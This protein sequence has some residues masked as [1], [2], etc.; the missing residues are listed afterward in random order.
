MWVLVAYWYSLWP[1]IRTVEVIKFKMTTRGVIVKLMPSWQV[2]APTLFCS[3]DSDKGRHYTESNKTVG[4]GG[5]DDVIMD[6]GA[7]TIEVVFGKAHW[8]DMSSDEFKK[9]IEE[10]EYIYCKLCQSNFSSIES[11]EFLIKLK[12]KN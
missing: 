3:F 2:K 10:N 6:G 7:L 5:P 8:K 12:N 9:L 1:F 4:N 11:R